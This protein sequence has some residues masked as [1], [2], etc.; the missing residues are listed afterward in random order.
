MTYFAEIFP[1]QYQDEFR[2][3]LRQPKEMKLGLS[4]AAHTEDTDGPS[5]AHEQIHRN[6]E[7]LYWSKEYVMAA[8]E[9]LLN[10][11]DDIYHN[12]FV[13][14]LFGEKD[15]TF[16]RKEFLRNV[17]GGTMKQKSSWLFDPS[18]LR[19]KFRDCFDRDMDK[20]TNNE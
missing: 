11:L 17:L 2:A 5:S 9:F 18:V 16:S 4:T 6:Q 15:S 8:E 13:N 7:D 19:I 20:E 1:K 14:H 3:E 12:I 10:D